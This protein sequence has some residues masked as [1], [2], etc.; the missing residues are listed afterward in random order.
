MKKLRRES[1]FLAATILLAA[2]GLPGLAQ[3]NCTASASVTPIVRVE[4][5]AE[6]VG[7]LVLICTGGMPTLLGNAVPQVNFALFLNTNISSHVTQNAPSIDFSEALVLVDEPN[8]LVNPP[9]RPLLNCGNNGAPDNGVGP[10]VCLIISNGNPL[11]TNDGTGNVSGGT[12][13]DGV[14]L[15]PAPNSYGCGRPNAFQGQMPPSQSNLLVFPGVPFDPPGAGTRIFRFTNV[16]VDPALFGGPNPVLAEI[17]VSG[18][19]AI[20]ITNPEQTVG[21]A[22]TGLIASIG[23]PGVVHVEEGF[24]NAFKDRNV[25]FTL[26]N[27]TFGG[28]S[29]TYNGGTAYPPQD[30]QNVPGVIYNDEDMFQWQNSALNAPP[31]PN[32]PLGYGGGPVANI[33]NSLASLGFGGVN[34]N[35]DVSGSASA[36]TR[37]AL[38]FTKV[39]GGATVT[40]PSMVFLRHVS[41]PP[42]NSGV[43]VL[44]TTDAAG[45]GPFT[46]G[47]STT[48][49]DGGTAV[50]EVLYA[51]PNAIEFADIPVVVNHPGKG[52]QVAVSFAPFYSTP[53]A[54]FATPTAAHPTPVAVPRFVPASGTMK[55]K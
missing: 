43:M 23:S 24:G 11:Q 14:G 8:S 22:Q 7:D 2:V 13:C 32:P 9:Q 51:D 46:A 28:V 33:G 35:I 30:A 54:G 5:N 39:P 3:V 12:P 38:T 18:E 52:T 21:F 25:A 44:T 45:A 20:T 4:G 6:P 53:G 17:S 37:I 40:V 26:L 48:I 16:R 49:P 19:L 1:R 15:D 47:A 29:Y 36:G 55:L 41:G 10:G 50:Y 27:A 31:S 34:T 42:T